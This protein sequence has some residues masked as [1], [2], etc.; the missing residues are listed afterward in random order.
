MQYLLLIQRVNKQSFL[1]DEQRKVKD[2][3]KIKKIKREENVA[4]L[5]TSKVS[6][7]AE[8]GLMNFMAILNCFHLASEVLA[9]SVLQIA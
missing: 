9:F 8:L 2:I 6:R 4:G 3:M 7:L 5:W 1:L